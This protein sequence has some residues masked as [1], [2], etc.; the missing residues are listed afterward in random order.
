MT[1][2][3]FGEA[4]ES[5]VVSVYTADLRGVPPVKE[6][7]TRRNLLANIHYLRKIYGNP[8]ANLLDL[9]RNYDD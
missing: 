9:R 7:A 6:L 5:A 8:D 1:L 4:L 3:F 2:I